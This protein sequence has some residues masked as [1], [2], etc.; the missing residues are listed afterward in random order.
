MSEKISGET[1]LVALLGDP[2]KHSKSPEMHNL[3]FQYLG[4]DYIYMAFEVKERHLKDAVEGLRSLNAVGFNLTMPHKQAVIPLLD[5]ISEEAKLCGAVNTVKND[6]GK[7]IGY[8]TDGMGFVRSLYDEG[9]Q[10]EGNKFTVIGAGGAAKSIVIRLAMEGAEE[11]A[12][13]NRSKQPANSLVQLINAYIPRCKINWFEIN[14]DIFKE[15]CK[16]SAV[17]INT[18]NVGMGNSINESIITDPDVFHHPLVVADIIYSP[19]KTKMLKMAEKEGCHII[20]GSGMI[21][22]QGALAFKIWTG[23]EMPV[24]LVRNS[25]TGQ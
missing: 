12:L 25:F 18:T 16:D 14:M 7:L 10:V 23:C 6:N 13:F 24:D 3:G 17:L 8:N 19:A 1:K 5:E 21:I 11:I 4:I 9:I 20:N 22:G 2:V 15:Q